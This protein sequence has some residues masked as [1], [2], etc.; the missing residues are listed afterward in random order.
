ML[1]EC[2]SNDE[3]DACR[4]F[5]RWVHVRMCGR[6]GSPAGCLCFWLF[7]GPAASVCKLSG[8]ALV[9]LLRLWPIDNKTIDQVA[10]QQAVRHWMMTCTINESN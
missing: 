8:R 4:Q 9:N 10:E 7:I 2:E 5:E 6:S 3:L 1:V